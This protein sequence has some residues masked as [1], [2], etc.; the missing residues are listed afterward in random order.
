M[1]KR[2]VIIKDLPG[3]YDKAENQKK[4]IYYLSKHMINYEI[5]YDKG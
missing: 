3:Q 1:G 2:R 5:W 4:V